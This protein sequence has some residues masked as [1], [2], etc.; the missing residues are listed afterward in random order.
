MAHIIINKASSSSRNN[1][2]QEVLHN[3]LSNPI[4][5]PVKK[6]E[7]ESDLEELDNNLKSNSEFFNNA[8]SFIV[9]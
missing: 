4:E 7:T 3:I 6:C 5:N 1:Y 2:N 9:I 8:V